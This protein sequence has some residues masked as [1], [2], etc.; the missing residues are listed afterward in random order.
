M[1]LHTVSCEQYKPRN[2]EG[3][4]TPC[5]CLKSAKKFIRNVRFIDAFLKANAN[6]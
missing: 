2:K 5:K 4:T 3:I 1:K 6:R